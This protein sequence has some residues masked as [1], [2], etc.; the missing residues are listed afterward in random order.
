M[1]VFQERD[2]YP[3]DKPIPEEHIQKYKRGEAMTS[4]STC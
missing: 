2:P 1:F 4:V 3:G